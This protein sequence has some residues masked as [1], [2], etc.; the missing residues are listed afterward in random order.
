MVASVD[1]DR[2]RHRYQ[3][4]HKLVR[5]DSIG[6][7]ASVLD[8][9]STG[10]AS[11]F[12]LESARE[13]QRELSSKHSSNSW[14]YESVKLLHFC[15]KTIDP[16]YDDLP[17]K[18]D[19]RRWFT[20]LSTLRNKTRGHGAT[21]SEVYGRLCIP[22]EKS[23]QLFS[24]N[25]C[26]FKRPWAF[27]YRNLSGKYR[28]TKL[29]TPAEEFDTLK[30]RSANLTL[31]DGI[32]VFM[33]QMTRVDLL[34]SDADALDFFL[35][36]GAF[37]EKNFEAISYVT[38]SRK[39]FDSAPYMLPTTPLPV[40]ETQGIGDLEIQGKCFG[41][42]PPIQ[43]GYVQRKTL[44]TELLKALNNDRHPIIT[45]VGRGGIGKTW[46]TLSVLHN[47][48]N[49]ENFAAI[50][51]FSA[52]DIDL[53]PEGPKLV[54]PQ[55]LNSTDIAIEFTRLVR[56]SEN[57]KNQAAV[58]YFARMMTKSDFGPILFVFDNFETVRNPSELYNWIDTYIRSPNKSLITTRMREF[59][60]DY[61]IE[62]QGM[63]DHESEELIN[64]TAQSLKISHLLT[65]QY[66]KAL[67]Q[68]SMG[69]PYVMKILLGEVAKAGK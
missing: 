4:L 21:P 7:W 3:Q 46:L 41:N 63:D 22:C 53:K 51:W 18:V 65:Q 60:G 1:D 48:A 30:T 54:R 16:N 19:G 59:K 62:I 11:Q 32:Y 36:N 26:L 17:T 68:E 15:V 33:G 61:P 31:Q 38:N 56:P 47:L 50:L 9:V 64:S 24:D 55:V 69:H 66:K 43:K 25:F 27:L 20:L 45:L 40:S 23:L 10:P 5:A 29:T 44:E 42:L 35:P 13:E 8:D 57:L 52:R 67:F 37:N 49:D 34:Y 6:E 2:D 39:Y 14:V 58:E 12:L 28:V